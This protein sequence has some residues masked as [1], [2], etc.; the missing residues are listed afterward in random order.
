M[1]TTR[2]WKVTGDLGHLNRYICDAK[3]TDGGRWVSGIN[4]L[5][6]S[7]TDEMMETKRAF[8]KTGGNAAFH[9]YQSFVIGEI[10]PAAAHEIGMRLAQDLWGDEFEVV[11]ATHIDHDHIHNHY[12]INAVSFKDGHRLWNKKRNYY[13]LREA[14]DA[15]CKEHG[16]SVV[17]NPQFG[18]AKQYAE[19]RDHKAGKATYRDLV[20]KD[21]DTAILASMTDTHF[22]GY[23]KNLGYEIKVGKDISV[24]LPGKERFFRIARNLGDGYTR[25]AIIRRILAQRY[26]SRPAR[27]PKPRMARARVGY[28]PRR[29]MTGLYALY[30]KYLYL[31]GYL[32]KQSKAR[33]RR[34]SIYLKEEIRY[35]DKLVE[36]ME[37]LCRNRIRDGM[38]LFQYRAFAKDE[39]ETLSR[40]RR[41]LVKDASLPA[42]KKKEQVATVDAKLKMWRHE[43]RVCDDVFER[44]GVLKEKLRFYASEQRERKA[45]QQ[46]KEQDRGRDRGIER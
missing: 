10:E 37:L 44:S 11:V 12:A 30:I 4:C 43:V 19:W 23:L 15:L 8:R 24:R 27:R 46:W 36:G 20:K 17:Q 5:P 39:I 13:A 31:L 14:S 21:V 28:P 25:E 41:A 16:L 33:Q 7:A 42:D 29:K 40:H 32:P 22:F 38:E 1:A 3:K 45:A 35:L 6:L 9:A 18:R 2:I 26:P 34:A